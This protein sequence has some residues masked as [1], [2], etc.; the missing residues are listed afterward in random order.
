[1]E[2]PQFPASDHQFDINNLEQWF[3][4]TQLIDRD[5]IHQGYHA[6]RRIMSV[7]D[8][9]SLAPKHDPEK[10][11]DHRDNPISADI[12]QSGNHDLS[13]IATTQSQSQLPSPGK[14]RLFGGKSA[15]FWLA[16]AILNLIG[17]ISAV[18][19]VILAVVLPNITADLHGSSN[20]AF[21]SGTAFLAAATIAQ[22]V[23]GVFS[24]IFGRRINLQIA[25]FFFLLGSFLCGLAPKMGMFVG[26][27]LVFLL[28]LFLIDRFKASE[29]VG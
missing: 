19:A 23:F 18:D 10:P 6:E 2:R 17:F 15:R 1:M 21:W 8:S 5:F 7:V 13:I 26:A 24:E 3:Y 4:K 9:I 28:Q 20:E 11:V 29:V 12:E 25:L 27:R 14:K 22:P 16:F